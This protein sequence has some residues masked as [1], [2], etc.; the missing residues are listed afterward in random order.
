MEYGALSFGIHNFRDTLSIFLGSP[1][2]EH[3]IWHTWKCLIEALVTLKTGH[4]CTDALLV[5]NNDPSLP[6][7]EGNWHPIVH[8]DIK[9]AKTF[10]EDVDAK[11]RFYR[12]PL[13]PDLEPAIK[14]G[15]YSAEALRK[16]RNQGTD[17]WKP[18][19]R[20]TTHPLD[21]ATDD[22]IGATN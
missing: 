22:M 1:L 8:M 2:P 12:K 3:Y 15:D 20:F 10:I 5:S 9:S 11:H 17:E 18:S 4:S 7:R 19:V 14:P 21:L 16:E 6:A 13:L